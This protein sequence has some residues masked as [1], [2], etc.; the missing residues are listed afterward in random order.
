MKSFSKELDRLTKQAAIV[1]F[2]NDTDNAGQLSWVI[3]GIRDTMLEYQV[4]TQA[5]LTF[6][7]PDVCFRCHCNKMSMIRAVGSL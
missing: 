7:V 6:P 1:G 3:D 4:R 2:T 5:E